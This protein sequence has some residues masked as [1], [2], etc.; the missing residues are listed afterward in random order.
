M[1][2]LLVVLSL[3]VA[4]C[5]EREATQTSTA[6]GPKPAPASPAPPTP[7]EAG[8]LVAGSAE[9]SEYQFT[10]AA[11]SLPMSRTAMNAPALE[12]ANQLKSAKW[13]AF[14]GDGKVVLTEKAKN[15]RRFLVRQNGFVDIV[16]LAKKEFLGVD[17][18]NSNESAEPTVDFRWNWVPNE[19]GSVFKT[20][21]L[22][23]RY[24]GEQRAR[25]TLL[26]DGSAWTVLRIA[27]LDP[28]PERSEGPPE[29]PD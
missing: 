21:M 19:I 1:R 13:I 3:V 20:G 26:W 27:V 5:G 4:A 18:V 14:D 2:R 23:D 24:T 11:F 17:S 22:K 15:D 29:R 25:A 10:N 16:P 6:G 8:A 12:V 7:D 9:F 28:D